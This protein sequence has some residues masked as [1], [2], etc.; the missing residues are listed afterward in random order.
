MSQTIY[1]QLR[2]QQ[3]QAAVQA[4]RN[5]PAITVIDPPIEPVKKIRTSRRVIALM[6]IVAGLCLGAVWLLVANP[7][8]EPV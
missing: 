3:E 4:V 5:T 7:G 1:T 8:G 2:L 6:G